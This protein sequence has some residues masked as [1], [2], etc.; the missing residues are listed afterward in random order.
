MYRW[1]HRRGR[2]CFVSGGIF[3]FLEP[4]LLLILHQ[5]KSHGYELIKELKKLVFEEVA[6]GPVYRMLRELEEWGFVSSTWDTASAAGPARRVYCLSET[7]HYYLKE[8]VKH[9]RQTKGVIEKF[10]DYY[11][12]HMEEGKG[13]YH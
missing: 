3:R 2:E 12:K 11:E 4:W 7:G 10:L 1:R 13:E 6:P 8:W 5:G 9:L